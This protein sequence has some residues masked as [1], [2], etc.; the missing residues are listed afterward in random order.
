MAVDRTLP[1]HPEDLRG[2]S[3]L[4]IDGVIGVTDLA[5]HLH[6]AIALPLRPASSTRTLGIARGVYSSVRG[7]T[8]LVGS[9]LDVALRPL[10]SFTPAGTSPVRDDLRA[11]INGVFGDHLEAASNPLAIRPGLSLHGRRLTLDAPLHLENAP[12]SLVVFIHGLC[13]HPGH[14]ERTATA[15]EDAEG[16]NGRERPSLPVLLG[17][18]PKRAGLHFHY[19]SGRTIHA[20]G[21]DLA[22]ALENLVKCWPQEVRTITLV[23]HSMGG[24]LA[25]SAAHQG[26]VSDHRW[27]KSL[28]RIIALGS[29][30]QG[31]PLERAGHLLDRL[32]GASRY[33]LPF[34]RL[35]GARSAGIVDLRHGRLLATGER[36]TLPSGTRLHLVAASRSSPEVRNP[37]GDGLVP[38]DSALF[39]D[40]GEV[41]WITRR[42]I[43]ACSHLGLMTHPDVLDHVRDLLGD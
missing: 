14:W 24:L 35:G 38:V 15:S 12:T 34:V 18:R 4:V 28:R 27:T 11:V 6:A 21:R 33:S 8:R 19:N 9:G 41:P 16:E 42:R 32:L 29:P 40:A 1:L 31:A 25:R 5:E 10:A 37:V 43:A 2:L 39:A 3:Q 22:D 36:P 17:R 20:N 26:R 30:H 23:G 7:I 13:L